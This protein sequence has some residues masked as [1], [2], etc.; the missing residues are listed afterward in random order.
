MS[1]RTPGGTRTPGWIPLIYRTILPLYDIYS[2][3]TDS[4]LKYPQKENGS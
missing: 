1:S 4:F 3:P 2:L